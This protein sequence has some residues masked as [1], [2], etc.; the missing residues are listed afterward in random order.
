MTQFPT[1]AD[2]GT[3]TL[4]RRLADRGPDSGL[5]APDAAAAIHER[6]DASP[7]LMRAVLEEAFSLAIG[8]GVLRVTADHVSSA[9][10]MHAPAVA[11]P[12]PEAGPADEVGGEAIHDEAAHAEPV[13]NEPDHDETAARQEPPQDASPAE[14]PPVEMQGAE[15]W[16]EA[17][18]DETIAWEP[19]PEPSPSWIHAHEA[20]PHGFDA[21]EFH[22]SEEPA[23]EESATEESATEGFATEES[24]PGEPAPEHAASENAAPEH[25]A[26]EHAAPEH[27]A[28]EHFAPGAPDGEAD[29]GRPAEMADAPPAE[30]AARVS[31]AFPWIASS[32]P[33]Y[34]SPPPPHA[35]RMSFIQPA[36]AA[37]FVDPGEVAPLDMGATSPRLVPPELAA[38]FR[39]RLGHM[40]AAVAVALVVGVTPVL[41]RGHGFG[42]APGGLPGGASGEAS[43]DAVVTPVAARAP[44]PLAQ[45][46]V[47]VVAADPSAP[48]ATEPVA[49]VAV[50]TKPAPAADPAPAVRGVPAAV[51]EAQV[52]PA[53]NELPGASQAAVDAPAPQASRLAAT[54]AAFARP[55]PALPA[56]AL[57]HAGLPQ[58]VEPRVIVEYASADPEQEVKASQLAD[59]LRSGGVAV[60]GIAAASARRPAG[61]TYAFAED[62]AGAESVASRLGSPWQARALPFKPGEG[63]LPEPGLVRLS[64][65]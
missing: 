17:H 59:T 47:A 49:A 65:P 19:P 58:G 16:L 12:A 39:P 60:V 21:A 53:L 22:A 55:Q 27:A 57:P 56:A 11:A 52:V 14:A 36:P 48:A 37:M 41:L 50:E 44:A 2:G 1:K 63:D 25:A 33:A 40:M 4:S 7:E 43:G 54:P 32:G 45:Q 8:E 9:L 35:R 38:S 30:P 26:P 42:G 18:P 5:L 20:L 61:V 29:H 34:V 46:T 23:H 15:A 10:A 51:R 31:A 3:V 62:R 6:C 13:H 28:L 64:L 24:G